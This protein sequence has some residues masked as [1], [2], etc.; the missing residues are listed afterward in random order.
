MILVR[1]HFFR[2]RFKY[3]IKEQRRLDYEREKQDKG[4]SLGRT[5]SIINPVQGVKNVKRKLSM[6]I[7]NKVSLSYKEKD[8]S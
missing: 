5:M 1:I 7:G 3:I 2:Q 6:S 4:F 8:W